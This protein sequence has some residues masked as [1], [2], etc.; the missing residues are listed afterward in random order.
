MT[1]PPLI[2][3]IRL[4]QPVFGAYRLRFGDD[5]PSILAYR[6]IFPAGRNN[7][8]EPPPPPYFMSSH[9]LSC[10]RVTRGMHTQIK[11]RA[12]PDPFVLRHGFG[13]RNLVRRFDRRWLALRIGRPNRCRSRQ[14]G[15]DDRLRGIVRRFR[16]ATIS[17][18]WLVRCVGHRHIAPDLCPKG[19][20]GLGRNGPVPWNCW[21][22]G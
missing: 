17:F 22:R 6:Y 20:K 1:N 15:D 10:R 3:V 21:L 9:G 2:V 5:R 19:T 13:R 12:P 16:C 8:L 14:V 11:Q 4:S 7:D 18:S